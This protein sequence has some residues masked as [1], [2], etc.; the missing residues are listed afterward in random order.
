MPPIVRSVSTMTLRGP[1]SRPAMKH[2]R[3]WNHKAWSVP[4]LKM[5]F[6]PYQETRKK[7]C[8]PRE[9][10]P[11][12]IYMLLW[13][14]RPGNSIFAERLRLKTLKRDNWL[15]L[16]L[17]AS[18]GGPTW[19]RTINIKAS[20]A[21]GSLK[22]MYQAHFSPRSLSGPLPDIETEG[23]FLKF[24]PNENKTQ[25]DSPC[26]RR[27]LK[28]T[29]G[30]QKKKSF[31]RWM[32]E[33]T[34]KTLCCFWQKIVIM[35]DNNN[36][37]TFL[38]VVSLTLGLTLPGL[39][40]GAE[41]SDLMILMVG[42][43]KVFPIF[44]TRFCSANLRRLCRKLKW[45]VL[46]ILSNSRSS[47]FAA[48]FGSCGGV[49][50]QSKKVFRFDRMPAFIENTSLMRVSGSLESNFNYDFSLPIDSCCGSP[51]QS[52]LSSRLPFLLVSST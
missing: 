42:R 36:I 46:D 29:Q 30:R 12:W 16:K 4:R 37:L 27:K 6:V 45:K 19:V 21:Q 20:E 22:R 47:P 9:P 23:N 43:K 5:K 2:H 11:K 18:D 13:S 40:I 41:V 3:S 38:A 14:L 32:N 35:Y 51:L 34:E 10:K 25:K 50:E 8:S 17:A 31:R 1:L 49:S 7:K 26:A 28:I 15:S 33:G 44:L 24:Q 48:I 52:F 39:A